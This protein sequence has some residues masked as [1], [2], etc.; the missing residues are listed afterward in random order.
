MRFGPIACRY[1]ALRYNS[2][3]PHC[4]DDAVF[5]LVNG[6]GLA[7]NCA[8]KLTCVWMLLVMCMLDRTGRLAIMAVP[9]V[10]L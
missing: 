5:P 1:F 6:C 7:L 4:A 10:Q 8:S 3:I 9:A 2:V